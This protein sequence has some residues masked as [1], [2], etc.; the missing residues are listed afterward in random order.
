MTSRELETRT[1]SFAKLIVFRMVS[2]GA[3]QVC[4]AFIVPLYVKR[5]MNISGVCLE[6]RLPHICK[7]LECINRHNE[8]ARTGVQVI[9]VART[10]FPRYNEA[11]PL[12]HPSTMPYFFANAAVIFEIRR[13]KS[14]SSMHFWFFDAQ[15]AA[16]PCWLKS[17][18]SLWLC[19]S[20]SIS[21]TFNVVYH[22]ASARLWGVGSEQ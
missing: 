4:A 21:N 1:C 6:A 16:N 8:S 20:H 9:G 12:Q 10:K 7:V 2:G 15:G 13:V 11:C 3:L 17:V 14:P 19:C 18:A 22:C 5:W